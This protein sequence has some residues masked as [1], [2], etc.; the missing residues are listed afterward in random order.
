MRDLGEDVDVLC[1]SETWLETDVVMP[2]SCLSDYDVVCAPAIRDR[3]RG[4]ASGGLAIFYKKCYNVQVLSASP[5]WLIIKLRLCDCTCVVCFVYF[6]PSLE[7]CHICDLLQPTLTDISMDSGESLFIFGGDF[8]ARVG[9]GGLALSEALENT[10]LYTTR[11]SRDVVEDTRGRYLIDFMSSNSLILLNGRT[12]GDIPADYTYVGNRGSSVIDLV[13]CQSCSLDVIESLRVVHCPTLSDHFPLY[14]KLR[15]QVPKTSG[16]QRS[17]ETA[18]KFFWRQNLCD[19]YVGNLLFSPRVRYAGTT[20]QVYENFVSAVSSAARAAGMIRR[21]GKEN[22][23]NNK[24]W[25]DAECLEHKKTV[26]FS[27]RQCRTSGFAEPF[28]GRYLK[29][30]RQYKSLIRAKKV[31]FDQTVTLNLSCSRSQAVFW[32][33]VNTYRRKKPKSDAVSLEDWEQFYSDIVRTSHVGRDDAR[34]CDARHPDLDAPITEQELLAS[35]SRCRDNK[36]PGKDGI[37]FEFLK[38]LPSNWRLYLLTLFNDIFDSG[39]VPKDWCEV[40]LVMLHKKGPINNPLNYRGIALFSCLAK[41]F[42][43]VFLSRLSSWAEANNIIPECQN[44]FRQGRG[45]RDGVFVLSSVIQLHLRLKNRKVF[46]AFVDFR[47]AFDSVD[48]GLLWRKLYSV[49]VSVRIINLFRNLYDGAAMQIRSGSRLSAGFGVTSGV[50]QGEPLSPVFFSLFLSDIEDYFRL[51]EA[52]GLNVDGHTDVLMLLYADDL[53][54]LADSAPDLNRKLRILKEYT[55]DNNL[56]VNT[57]KT[58]V[59]CFRRAGFAESS[60]HAFWF[61]E[62][63]LEVVSEYSYLGVTFSSSSLFRKNAVLA[64]EGAKVSV[65]AVMGLFAKANVTS[66]E[67]RLTL[68]NTIVVNSLSYCAPVWAGRYADILE[69]VQVGFF[70]R[71]LC[72]PRNTPDFMVR[73][74]TGTVKLGLLIFSLSLSFLERLLVL[75]AA[76]LPR[77]CFDRLHH[78]DCHHGCDPAYNWVTQLRS[79]FIDLQAE[80]LWNSYTPENFRGNRTLIT[81]KFRER[82]HLQDVARFHESSYSALY[83]QLRV[84]EAP[85]AYLLHRMPILYQRIICQLRLCNKKMVRLYFRGSL[86]TIDTTVACSI[87]NMGENETISHMLFRCPIYRPLRVNLLGMDSNLAGLLDTH[88]LRHCKVLC[89][90]VMGVLQLR[91]FAMGE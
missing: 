6:K 57:S 89:W 84:S 63:R 4:R 74:E 90:F 46:A 50:L 19:M 23:F 10:D 37:P 9:S 86:H 61:G 59:M 49:G 72:L 56:E 85:A 82:L 43:Q 53:V 77:A 38:H 20:G 62:Q 66:W 5:W 15:I 39:C 2:P 68:F 78:L 22:R 36:A 79:I 24:P 71:L 31:A 48:H 91:S 44:G 69:R 65:G 12:P 45:C 55:V 8:N 42:S 34:F 75:P 88:D 64:V 30:K 76:R 1:I 25:F 70:K 41:V 21:A 52:K 7:I 11:L 29:A 80:D 67:A 16:D 14:L 27:L 13:W 35:L 87:C 58:K 83:N 60:R 40:V 33:S 26:R 28:K 3:S 81:G 17:V 18:E 32:K 47:R 51:R 54:L 73:L